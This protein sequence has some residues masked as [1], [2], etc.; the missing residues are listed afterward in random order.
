MLKKLFPLL[1]LCLVACTKDD[2]EVDAPSNNFQF[3]RGLYVLNEGSMGHNTASL[4]F[5][6]LKNRDFISDVFTAA[7]PESVLGLGDTGNDLQV[8]G[9][10]LYAVINGS[11]K[12]EIMNARNAL[13]LAQINIDAPRSIAFDAHEQAY[14]SSFVSPAA[15]APR[16]QVVRFDLTTYEIT[17]RC[18]VGMGPE[19]MVVIGDSLYVA[20]SCDPINYTNFENSIS[21][22]DLN[23]FEVVGSIEVAPN[24]RH[25]RV[26]AD[27][28][29]WVN[30]QGNYGDIGYNLHRVRRVADSWKVDNLNIACENF[31]IAKAGIFG[32]SPSWQPEISY[33][34]V[35]PSTL[36]VST[37][38]FQEQENIK[39]PSTMIFMPDSTFYITDA[40][41]YV[42]SGVLRAYDKK[43]Q[44]KAQYTT[45]DIPGHLAVLE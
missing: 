39:T 45:G 20:N 38:N 4:D 25:L 12:V 27:G 23:T 36:N 13:S 21:I 43:G 28:N 30:S 7:N 5:L 19:E 6:N 26:D 3:E 18:L 42:S 22:I 17:G 9:A 33:F 41:N 40:K 32:F 31:T 10:C 24:L 2:P 16:G 44:L 11:N 29:L 15:D 14:V 34:H 35:D 37:W 1:G 8:H